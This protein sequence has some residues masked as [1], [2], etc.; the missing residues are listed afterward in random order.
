MRI[1]EWHRTVILM[2]L[3]VLAVTLIIYLKTGY[4]TNLENILG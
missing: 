2:I 4:Q 1:K 3:L